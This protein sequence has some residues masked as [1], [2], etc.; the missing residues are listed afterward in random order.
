MVKRLLFYRVD[1]CRNHS[2]I[3]K[4]YKPAIGDTAAEAAANAAFGNQT[5]IRAK[6]T[7]NFVI[8]LLI[9]TGFMDTHIDTISGQTIYNC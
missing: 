3:S 6:L 2:A 7:D 8:F 4:G 1:T 5:M 9:V